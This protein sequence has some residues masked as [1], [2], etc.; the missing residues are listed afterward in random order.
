[1]S[2]KTPDSRPL[3]RVKSLKTGVTV[4]G[5]LRKCLK[6]VP[7]LL[8]TQFEEG[9]GGRQASCRTLAGSPQRDGRGTAIGRLVSGSGRRIRD[10]CP[11][12]AF[13]R[14]LRRFGRVTIRLVII[15]A[16]SSKKRAITSGGI[17]S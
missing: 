11:G 2:M 9:G 10:G 14:Q 6:R 17:L 7:P 12:A 5:Y 16:N 8:R 4:S 13:V 3:R 15:E 1:M